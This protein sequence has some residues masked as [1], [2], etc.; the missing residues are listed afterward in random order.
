MLKAQMTGGDLVSRLALKL[1]V[2]GF[3]GHWNFGPGA[4]RV[5][6]TPRLHKNQIRL[7]LAQRQMV[8]AHFDFHRIAQR[9]EADQFNG[10]SHQQPHFEQATAVFG[11]HFD[12]GDGA[13][14]A[15]SG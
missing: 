15:V 10:S 1:W 14:K 2:W 4:C 7:M 8:A 13:G 12:F 11:R 9:R 6:S 5:A 3:S